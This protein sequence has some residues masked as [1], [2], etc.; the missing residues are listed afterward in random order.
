MEREEGGTTTEEELRRFCLDRPAEFEVPRDAHL[1]RALPRNPS[2]QA[3]TR[4]LREQARGLSDQG[5]S[6][7]IST[8]FE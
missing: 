8:R 5:W 1:I 7:V 6:P 4:M 2:G 3:L